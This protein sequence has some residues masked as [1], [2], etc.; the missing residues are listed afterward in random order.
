MTSMI[1]RLMPS[2]SGAH[3]FSVISLAGLFICFGLMNLSGLT[4][5]TIGRWLD[6]HPLASLIQPYKSWVPYILGGMQLFAGVMIAIYAVP[7]RWKRLSYGL[8]GLLSLASLSLMLTN[9]VWINSLGGFPAIGSGQGIIKYVAI[10]GVALWFLGAKGAREIM[11]LGLIIVLGWI[12]AM[13]FT[14][15]EA[16][17]VWPLLTGSPVFNW[18]LTDLG[19]QM[20]SN[21]VGVIE[22]VTVVL[23]TGYWWN[24]K[25]YEVGLV[26]SAATFVVTLSF[27]VT[28]PQSWSG[29]F[30]SLSGT[31][32]F[33]LKDVV[34]LAATFILYRD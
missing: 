25:A 7:Q 33:L 31:G 28:F 14:G 11:L 9:P 22:L 13:K 18:W 4:D 6:P 27:L 2:A 29:G 20:A 1:S 16:D 34:L 23:L 30:P 21:I 32:H 26:L 24:R 15:P 8:I 10:L 12:G 17:G 3:L 5:G 19:K